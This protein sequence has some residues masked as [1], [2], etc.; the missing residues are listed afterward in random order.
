MCSSPETILKIW[1]SWFLLTILIP[2]P[3]PSG[4][5]K[6]GRWTPVCLI[7]SFFFLS[8]RFGLSIF[9]ESIFIS[10]FILLYLFLNFVLVIAVWFT[11]SF[12]CSILPSNTGFFVQ[13]KNFM[14][15]KIL[16]LLIP[17]FVLQYHTFYFYMF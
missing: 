10:T 1:L 15:L 17:P 3:S 16:I 5:L 13:C 12:T 7:G 9:Y 11:T 8:L 6:M 4:T 14:N 2:A